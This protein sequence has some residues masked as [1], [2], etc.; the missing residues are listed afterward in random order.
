MGGCIDSETPRPPPSDR[1]VSNGLRRRPPLGQAY[2][3][4]STA[5]TPRW[6]PLAVGHLPL[7]PGAVG[8]GFSGVGFLR[9]P[10]TTRREVRCWGP[11]GDPDGGSYEDFARSADLGSRF[12]HFA[13][14]WLKP[15]TPLDQ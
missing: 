13:F 15:L 3:I 14:N 1:G 9:R 4:S 6:L 5:T 7:E 2:P 12:R 8:R 11:D 10:E